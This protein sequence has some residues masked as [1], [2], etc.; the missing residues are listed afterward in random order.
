MRKRSK[1]ITV[2][3]FDRLQFA[4]RLMFK[5]SSTP[6]MV[7][8]SWGNGQAAWTGTLTGMALMAFAGNSILCRLALGA[9]AIDPA[10]YTA[11]RLISGALTLG[12]IAR[13]LGNRRSRP[14]SSGSWGG[15]AL[16]F[17]YAIAFAYAY[18]SLSAGTGALILFAAVQFTMIASAFRSGEKP[19][20]LEWRGWFVAMAGLIYLVFPGLAAPSF[21]GSMLMAA[22]GIAWGAYSLRGRGAGDPVQ[23]TADNFWRA[24]PLV[25]VMALVQLPLLTA[26]PVGVI[27]A[28][29][30]GTLTSGLGYLI[31]YAALP[32]LT[33][34]RAATLQLSVP[35]IAA[36]GGVAFLSEEFTARSLI[37]AVAILGGIGFSM[38]AR[39]ASKNSASIGGT[40]AA[41]R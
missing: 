22:A 34:T 15:G 8:S 38:S 12:L 10:S 26:S 3:I 27:W 37:A 28:A 20:P 2:N 23:T 35:V 32:R 31:W 36:F 30:S 13:C 19:A 7:L 17:L 18:R 14:G 11:V 9:A 33:A 1:P 39:T 24:L 21:G 40:S 25:L 5:K 29:L 16:L 41:S 4:I 6:S